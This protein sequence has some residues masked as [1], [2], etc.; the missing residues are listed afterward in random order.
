MPKPAIQ[1][2]QADSAT[3]VVTPNVPTVCSS[4]LPQPEKLPYPAISENIPKLEKYL[5]ET[6][7]DIAL[8]ILD[9][10]TSA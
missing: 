6:F 9:A 3:P 7:A 10:A 4:P 5:Q 8:K 2:L 1:S